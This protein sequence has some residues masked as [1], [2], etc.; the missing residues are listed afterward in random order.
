MPYQVTRQIQLEKLLLKENNFKKSNSS[1]LNAEMDD[2]DK[3]LSEI[4]DA[5]NS[6]QIGEVVRRGT[7]G[8]KLSRRISTIGDIQPYTN[9]NDSRKNSD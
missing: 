6:A 4:R 5:H 2:Y 3:L 1:E 7:L 9:H 8:R